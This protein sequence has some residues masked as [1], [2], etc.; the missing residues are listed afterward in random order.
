M[1]RGLP[2]HGTMARY[3]FYRCRCERCRARNA[4]RVD[5]QR[6]R[7]YP[8]PKD[9]DD[10]RHGTTSFYTNNGCR[11]GRCTQAM[12]DYFNHKRQEAK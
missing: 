4:I 5:R 9:P 11:C 7:H 3:N 1:S 8:L 2:D 10:P 12:T 6:Q